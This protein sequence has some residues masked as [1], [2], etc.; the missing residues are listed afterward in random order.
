[1]IAIRCLSDCLDYRYRPKTSI[2]LNNIIVVVKLAI[3]VLFLLVGSFYVKPSNW[4]PAPGGTGILEARGR[5]LRLGFDAMSSSAAEVKMP[6]ATCRL[7]SW[8]LIICTIFVLV[9]GVLTGMVFV[10]TVER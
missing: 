8:D 7:G 3:I 1:M 6:S 4:T 5:L 2:R 10:Q 9:S